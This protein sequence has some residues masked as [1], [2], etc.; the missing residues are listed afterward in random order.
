MD[1]INEITKRY[2]DFVNNYP[3][4]NKYYH[5]NSVYNF[6]THFADIKD[7]AAS[8]AAYKLLDTYFDYI[9]LNTIDSLEKCKYIFYHYIQPIGKI[10]TK[11]A[12]FTYILRPQSLIVYL[13]TANLLLLLFKV[14][15]YIL[16]PLNL[17]GLGFIFYSY[18]KIK[19][20]KVFRFNW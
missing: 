3:E 11:Y 16:I 6:I 1:N 10:F 2:N 20:T 15:Y 18:N 4:K 17:L 8:N 5:L 9:T 7:L 14:N 12:N 13:I 19:S